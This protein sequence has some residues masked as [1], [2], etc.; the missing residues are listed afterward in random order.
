MCVCYRGCADSSSL[1][2]NVERA[3]L[4]FS[5]TVES[6]TTLKRPWALNTHDTHRFFEQITTNV[7]ENGLFIN[8]TVWLLSLLISIHLFITLGN[9]WKHWLNS[10]IQTHT[11]THTRTHTHTHTHTHTTHTGAFIIS[12]VSGVWHDQ[13]TG[14]Q[15][16]VSKPVC[17]HPYQLLVKHWWQWW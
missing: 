14:N 10:H 11:H 1:V 4:K 2:G 8:P 9:A 17:I 7:R 6:S 5:N 15:Q 13:G 12:S 16:S 3:R